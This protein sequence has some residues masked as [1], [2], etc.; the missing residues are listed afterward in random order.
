MSENWY[1]LHVRSQFEDSVGRKLDMLGLEQFSPAYPKGPRTPRYFSPPHLFPGYVFTR[2]HIDCARPHVMTIPGVIRILGIGDRA[3][4][5]DDGEIQSIRTMAL[6][7][8]VLTGPIDHLKEGDFV[9]V[10][11]GPLAGV[12]GFVLYMRHRARIIVSINLLNRAVSAEVAGEHL[13]LLH[14][15]IAA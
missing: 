8:D 11:H 6:A 15:R 4:P 2:C 5:L 9:R 3:E 14:P 1:V 10:T 12:E 7:P 13:E